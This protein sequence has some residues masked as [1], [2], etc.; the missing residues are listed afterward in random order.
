MAG[1]IALTTTNI[2]TQF[3]QE[4]LGVT[5]GGRILGPAQSGLIPS[6]LAAPRS[7]R[8]TE[9]CSAAAISGDE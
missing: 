4:L 8:G 9:T 5:L 1:H 6:S 3:A 2:G 7:T